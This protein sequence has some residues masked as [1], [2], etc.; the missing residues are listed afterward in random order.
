MYNNQ[1]G[2]S[3]TPTSRPGRPSPLMS[4]AASDLASPL[5]AKPLVP[6]A[7]EAKLA[8]FLSAE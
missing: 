1:I 7:T 2:A 8:V 6:T 4:L 3:F 5:T